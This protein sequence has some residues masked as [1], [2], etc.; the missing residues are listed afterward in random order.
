[1][2][3]K[4]EKLIIFSSWYELSIILEKYNYNSICFLYKMTIER[5]ENWCSVSD[6]LAIKFVTCIAIDI[7]IWFSKSKVNNNTNSEIVR[8][9]TS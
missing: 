7:I 6:R 4:K 5:Y 2:I 3:L 1:M 9:A 8:L